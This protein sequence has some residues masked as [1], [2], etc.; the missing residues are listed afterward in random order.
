V[1]IFMVLTII[2]LETSMS[3]FRI[4]ELDVINT[5]DNDNEYYTRIK[6]NNGDAYWELRGETT[7][8]PDNATI[9]ALDVF[10]GHAGS[11]GMRGKRLDP[12]V[13]VKQFGTLNL[14]HRD[15]RGHVAFINCL[16]DGE[17]WELCARADDP[18]E[19]IEKVWA[20]YDGPVDKWE[21]S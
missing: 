11:W 19:A 3:K 1:A 17:H 4:T 13:P 20:I 14:E 8:H 7:D 6:C 12:P 15:S 21:N 16:L 5:G 2:P 18:K 9:L 10:T